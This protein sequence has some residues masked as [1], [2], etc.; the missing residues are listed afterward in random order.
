MNVLEKKCFR[1]CCQCSSFSLS[2]LFQLSFSIFHTKLE[3][4]TNSTC[5]IHLFLYVPV[6]SVRSA[7]IV[8]R[9]L[10]QYSESSYFFICNA[11]RATVHSSMPYRETFSPPQSASP[12]SSTRSIFSSPLMITL[13]FHTDMNSIKTL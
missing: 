8:L 12:F 1:L 4:A 10:F 2:S 3:N 9:P 7:E 6:R 13:V 5:F 11:I